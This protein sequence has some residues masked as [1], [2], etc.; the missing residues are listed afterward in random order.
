MGID[1]GVTTTAATISPAH[2]LPYGGHRRRCAAE[3][4]RAQR[5]MARRRRPKRQAQSNGYQRARREAARLH[6][7]AARQNTHAARVWA[8]RVADDHHTIAIEDF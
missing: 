5:K 4:A 2:D 7:K 8:R 3:L 1:W 6:K